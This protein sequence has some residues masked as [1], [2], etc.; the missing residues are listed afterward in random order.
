MTNTRTQNIIKEFTRAIDVDKEYTR[1]ELSKT[2]TKVYY[3]FNWNK[4]KKTD[5]KSKKKLL[6]DEKPKKKREPTAYNI[7]V[8]ENMPLVKKK[9]PDLSRQDLMR[10]V[11]ELWREKK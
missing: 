9:Y 4:Q 6:N 3:I 2:L 7:F 11:A 8:K 5:D 10:K 1:A